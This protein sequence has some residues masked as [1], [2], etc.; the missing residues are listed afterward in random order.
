M[1][2]V[3]KSLK[4]VSF[5]V[6]GTTDVETEETKQASKDSLQ[7]LQK[8]MTDMRKLKDEDMIALLTRYSNNDG[9]LLVDP[10]VDASSMLT[11]FLTMIELQMRF[12]FVIKRIKPS[13]NVLQPIYDWFARLF[14]KYASFFRDSPNNGHMMYFLSKLIH[15]EMKLGQSN[16]SRKKSYQE[17]M[18][19]VKDQIKYLDTS[20]K[21][22][23]VA[24]KRGETGASIYSKNQL[25]LKSQESLKQQQIE[26]SQQL[27]EPGSVQRFIIKQ[28]SEKIESN[29]INGVI[30]SEKTR[31]TKILSYNVYYY[32][33]LMSC[34]LFIKLKPGLNSLFDWNGTK[35][36]VQKVMMQLSNDN[37]CEFFS[38]KYSIPD[39]KPAKANNVLYNYLYSTENNS[40]IPNIGLSIVGMGSRELKSYFD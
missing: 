39:M 1:T 13:E 30:E 22:L 2:D 27:I 36:N 35:D 3:I 31:Q 38:K 7:P 33:I 32:N 6:S 28:I 20:K 15:N 18:E 37:V 23:E 29:L 12:L 11:L 4:V 21:I 9:F 5:Y 24:K 26:A 14:V 8:F 34:L 10:A 40:D 25:L 19:Q 17:G 16:A